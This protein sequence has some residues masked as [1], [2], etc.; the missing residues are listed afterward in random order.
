MTSEKKSVQNE[1]DE[2]RRRISQFEADKRE[3]RDKLEDL[4]RIRITLLKKIEV[5]CTFCIIHRCTN[6]I[7]V[8]NTA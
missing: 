8:R 7:V 3:T 6:C 5:V 4:N 2:L 1:M